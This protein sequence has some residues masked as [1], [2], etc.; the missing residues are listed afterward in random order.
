MGEVE[1]SKLKISL[2]VSR[3]SEKFRLVAWQDVSSGTML[4]DET[5]DEH[6]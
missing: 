6:R 4:R 2:P 1:A 3:G 5:L